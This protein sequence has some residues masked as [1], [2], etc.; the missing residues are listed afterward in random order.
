MEIRLGYEQL[1]IQSSPDG[2][3]Q[4]CVQYE[5]M[6]HTFLSCNMRKDTDKHSNLM[7]EYDGME[8][9]SKN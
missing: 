7:K 8:Q 2:R 9:V 3:G 4:D 5:N 1:K 6:G